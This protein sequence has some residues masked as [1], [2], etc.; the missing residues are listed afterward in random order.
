MAPFEETV[1]ASRF[2]RRRRACKPNMLVLGSHGSRIETTGASGDSFGRRSA[3][4]RCGGCA[5]PTLGMAEAEIG[6]EIT[7]ADPKVHTKF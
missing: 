6:V 5:R 3:I 7:E 4:V 2:G 1:E